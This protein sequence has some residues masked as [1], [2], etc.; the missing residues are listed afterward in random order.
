MVEQWLIRENLPID[1]LHDH[2]GEPRTLEGWLVKVIGGKNETLLGPR[3]STTGEII[4]VPVPLS[5]VIKSMPQRS[6]DGEKRHSYELPPKY[7][8]A[9]SKKTYL[10]SPAKPVS[11]GQVSQ[12]SAAARSSHNGSSNHRALAST[13]S[14]PSYNSAV[15]SPQQRQ[16]ASTMRAVSPGLSSSSRNSSISTLPAM[17]V[18]P[19]VSFH[20]TSPGLFT[21]AHMPITTPIPRN[22]SISSISS[23]DSIIRGV[24]QHTPSTSSGGSSTR[25]Q[26][27]APPSVRCY[28]VT[29]SHVNLQATT[30]LVG[31]LIEKKTRNYVTLVQPD[32]IKLHRG[33]SQN[34]A[35]IKFTKKDDAEKAVRELRRFT[36]M[37]KQLDATLEVSR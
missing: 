18:P 24:A 28:K 2:A 6:C 29:L 8:P 31:E 7:Q 11:S 3:D 36:F 34:H 21:T 5:P 19:D 25:S 17:M 9:F 12:S 4:Q 1:T 26:L 16:Q 32:P 13:I 35:Y 37:G 33:K 22:S 20:I 30:E 27:A 23:I 14:P 10:T 15:H